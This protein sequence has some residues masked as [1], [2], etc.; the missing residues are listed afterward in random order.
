MSRGP[1]GDVLAAFNARGE[2]VPLPGG[3]GRAWR[4]GDVILKPCGLPAEVAW[5]AEVLSTMAATASYRVPQP[6]RAVDGGWVASGWEAWLAMPGEPDARRWDDVLTVGE[7]FHHALAGLPRPGFLDVRDDPWSYGDRVAWEERPLDGREVMAELL[8]P[9]AQARRPVDLPAQPVHGDL[10]GNVMF[11]EGLP[12]AVID[13]PLYFRPVSWALAVTVIDALTWYGA[14]DELAGRRA[15]LDEWDQMLV[16]ALMYRIATSEGC[17]RA[18][19]PV[20]ERSEHYTPV[21]D[22]VLSRLR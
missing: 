12:P 11:A 4:V 18:G 3:Q 13:W 9:L 1:S 16:R 14:P 8:L 17:R 20:R 22:L 5:V 2:P 19:L 7:A 15:D 21:V 6:V 10:L